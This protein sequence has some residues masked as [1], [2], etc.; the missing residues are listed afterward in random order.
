MLCFVLLRS[1]LVFIFCADTQA[2]FLA[3]FKEHCVILQYSVLTP[4]NTGCAE[5]AA[6]RIGQEARAAVRASRQGDKSFDHSKGHL[7]LLIGLGVGFR[8]ID[9]IMGRL[10][11]V[12][13]PT[14]RLV[15]RIETEVEREQRWTSIS[16]RSDPLFSLASSPGSHFKLNVRFG[17]MDPP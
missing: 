4:N 12:M 6:A 7:G 8:V 10:I 17:G 15:R 9:R 1:N 5:A 14:D 16:L 13:V 2:E 3:P 11:R